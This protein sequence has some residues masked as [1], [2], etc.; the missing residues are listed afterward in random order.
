MQITCPVCS[1]RYVMSAEKIGPNGRNVR[2]A[3]C[4]DVWFVAPEDNAPLNATISAGNQAADFSSQLDN[5]MNNPS[6]PEFMIRNHQRNDDVQLPGFPRERKKADKTKLKILAAL[7]LLLILI[8]AVMLA[9][10]LHSKPV[11]GQLVYKGKGLSFVDVKAKEL[12]HGN[13]S[14]LVLSGRIKNETQSLIA[15]P[16]LSAKLTNQ[17]SGEVVEW[18]FHLPQTALD[19]G[20]TV[21]FQINKND[22]SLSGDQVSL[23]F[24]LEK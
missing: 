9:L 10:N 22:L 7:A 2:C 14:Q 11:A 15:L 16:A 4:G 24:I 6:P 17:K 5:E 18:V 1:A 20:M 13:A 21:D 3:K 12:S 23:S 8:A 19:A